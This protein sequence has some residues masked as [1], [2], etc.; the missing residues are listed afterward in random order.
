MPA[1]TKN[2][3]A[4]WYTF[5]SVDLFAKGMPLISATATITKFTKAHPLLLGTQ[6]E[7]THL[8]LYC[9][10]REAIEKEWRAYHSREVW[11][12]IL[13]VHLHV[14][15]ATDYVKQYPP[16]SLAVEVYIVFDVT[17]LVLAFEEELIGDYFD[18]PKNIV[19]IN[20]V[21]AVPDNLSEEARKVRDVARNVISE[22]IQSNHLY[23]QQCLNDLAG[24]DAQAS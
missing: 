2:N 14:E 12:E 3:G 13:K 6:Y 22:S 17:R 11:W 9:L 20:F 23:I 8:L 15:P 7:C 18:S 5:K 1:G 10:K 24:E 21:M 19:A 4:P 16:N